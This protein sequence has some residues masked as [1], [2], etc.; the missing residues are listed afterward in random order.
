MKKI[1]CQLA[2]AFCAC[3][4]V[5]AC[6]SK[7]LP[8]CNSSEAQ[9]LVGEIVN[10]MPAAKIAGAKFVA[11]KNISELGF[12]KSEEIRSCHGNLVTT[13]GEDEI[14][15]SIFWEDK[16]KDLFYIQAQIL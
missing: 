9:T 14:Q 13:S 5:S 3:L 10:D 4:A 11:L 12:N 16:T 2:L 7:T 6:G 1:S 15:F 8:R